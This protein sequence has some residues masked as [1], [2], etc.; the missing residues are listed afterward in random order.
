MKIDDTVIRSIEQALRLALGDLDHGPDCP[1]CPT[2]PDTG[3]PCCPPEQEPRTN[4]LCGCGW[5]RL[6]CPV[7]Q[8]PESCP[9]CGHRFLSNRQ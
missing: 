1:T 6:G 8:L 2:D 7:S 3:L 9:I 4:V 5:G